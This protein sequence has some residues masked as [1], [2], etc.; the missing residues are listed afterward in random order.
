[1]APGAYV[2]TLSREHEANGDDTP[3]YVAIARALAAD[4][5]RNRLKAGERL[6]GSRKLAALLGVNRNTIHAA[7]HE[8]EAQGWV[9]AV[10]A[11][12]VFV[13]AREASDTPR[14][15]SR[16]VALRDQ[17]PARLGFDFAPRGH[18]TIG[19]GSG[20]GLILTGGVPDPRLFPNEL[21]A[22]AY[23]RALRRRGSE[24]LDYGDARGDGQLRAALAD[25]LTRQRALAA[26]PDDV[27]ITRGSQHAIWLAALALL[28]PGD[29]VGV[30]AWGYPPAWAALESAGATLVSL[31]VDAEGVRPDA[32][33]QALSHGP[34]RAL[35]LTPHHQYPTMVP[36]GARRRLALLALAKQHRIALLEDDYAHE[37]QFEGQPRLPLASADRAG[38]VVYIG[39]LSKILAPGLRIG[40][41]VAPRPLLDAMAALRTLSDRQGDATAEAAVAEL[42][43]DG[44][45]ERHARRVR[46]IYRA[47]RDLLAHELSARLGERVTFALPPGGMAMWL[48]VHGSVPE[49]W[50]ERAAARGVSFRAGRDYAVSTHLGQPSAAPFVRMGFTRLDEREL[51]RAVR[52]ASEVF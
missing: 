48:G 21:L 38:V 10:P 3:L 18:P 9:Q 16:A 44:E 34:L 13:R 6:P 5:A 42:L 45:V 25:Q 52:I 28:R 37:F 2:P 7:L 12:G 47:R 30:E 43:E 46:R 33:E 24:L 36:L 32:V 20:K 29:R 27:L 8:L 26:G 4:V 14:P 39:T 22:R 17:V 23:R 35:Y 31:A 40:Y 49:R 41:V 51:V 11:R 1:M 19:A 50:V 15:F